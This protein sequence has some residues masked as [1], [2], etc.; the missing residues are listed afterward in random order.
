M[1][2]NFALFLSFEGIRLLHRA[3]PGWHDVGEVSLEVEDLPT[4]LTAL[5]D[6]AQA[7]TASPMICKL[8]IPD[9]Q[10]KYLTFDGQ[11]ATGEALEQAVRTHLDGA[12][13]YALD[14][15][16]YD[17]SFEAGQVHVA[18]VAH[19]TLAEAEDFAT[20][21]GFAPVSFVARPA[22]GRFVGEPW[23]GETA[24]AAR[25][26]P[27]GETLERDTAPVRII[28]P[29]P[30]PDATKE[31]A[32]EDET[33][34][35]AETSPEPETPAVAPAP[36]DA[37]DNAPA[38]AGDDTPDTGS[39]QDDDDPDKTDDT[40]AAAFRSIRA[41]RGDP[42][43]S[44][45]RRL[46]GAARGFTPVAP[47][48]ANGDAPAAPP[49]TGQPQNA[50]SD[51]AVADLAASL[52][53]TEADDPP[54]PNPASPAEDDSPVSSF[55]TRRSTRIEATV[56][57]PPPPG[58]EKQRMTVFG[59]R[60]PATSRGKP[61][62]LGLILTAVLLLFLVAVAAWASVF[63]DDG[64][65]SL[66]RKDDQRQIVAT[67]DIDLPEDDPEAQADAALTQPDDQPTEPPA[68]A[69]DPAPQTIAAPADLSADEVRA[70]YAATGIW[71]MAP[72]APTAPGVLT[73]D[74][75]YQTSIDSQIK[76]S[77]AVALPDPSRTPADTR[78]ETPGDP[79][80]AGTRFR[81]DD[82]GLVVATPDGALTPQ[83]VPVYA[84]SPALTPPQLP[85]RPEAIVTDLPNDE[86][87]RLMG[88]RPRLRP[89]TLSEQNERGS[90]GLGGRTR[91]ELAALRPRLRPESA[92]E[93]AMAAA[94]AAAA[95]AEA[96]QTAAAATDPQAVAAALAEAVQAP[97]PFAS[98]TKQAVSASLKPNSRPRNFDKVVARTT[99]A[100][101]A[102]P[103]SASQKVT[104]NAPTTTTTVAR[105]ATDKNVISMR[106]VNLIGVYGSPSN[107]RA[108]VRLANG[109]Y[110][111]V[112]VGDRLDG[113][114]VAAIGDSELRY[115]KRGRSIVLR[116]PRG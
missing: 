78:P 18:A 5:R 79:P 17:W 104:P 59:A 75:F 69:P 66:F 98:A 48:A 38:T 83:G 34:P 93:A 25:H 11:G 112:K 8:V 99:Q 32:A 62:Y 12:T 101:R 103:V 89:D 21:H 111:K 90:L 81:F 22:Q 63:L 54:A 106:Q 50:M 64:I 110:Q 19:E 100:A 57:T 27:E 51:A 114:Q 36:S 86:V 44:A 95:Q 10:I 109:R 116:M 58:D 30:V 20:L 85:D 61:R 1:K 41:S 46:E 6:R 49:V 94:Q 47:G 14:D 56:P 9:A 92:Q 37:D 40:P 96:A 87:L 13:P 108:L 73:L 24:Q 4:E 65:A 35:A 80:A 55:F 3:F 26:L 52:A 16:A 42:P 97:D 43:P 91:V 102:A 105:A 107:R 33:P 67:P 28:G 77:D 23:F 53:A 72:D 29:A 60:E 84:G 39:P 88:V 71:Q 74:D 45:P 7:L 82:R 70:R 115:Q 15:L 76:S 68:E 31:T 2:P 113:G